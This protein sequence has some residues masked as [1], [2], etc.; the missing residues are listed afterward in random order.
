MLLQQGEYVSSGADVVHRHTPDAEI[1]FVTNPAAEAVNRSFNFPVKDRTP[2]LWDAYRGE[3]RKTH[4]WRTNNDSTAVTLNLEPDESVFVIFPK[5]KNNYHRLPSGE[6]LAEQCSDIDG[7]WDVRFEPK[8]A[9][10]FDR[11]L[12]VLTD[13]SASTDTAVKYFAGTATYQKT[14]RIDAGEVGKDK[15]ILLDLGA[16]H[17]I[18]EL[19]VN[20]KDAGV[21]WH[22]PY[23][24]DVTPYLK[25][26]DNT[27]SVA[28]SVNWANRLIG[29]EQYPADFE[30]GQDRGDL[31]RAMKAFPDWFINH[32]ARPQ[33]GRKT[34]NIWY[35]YRQD[36]PLQPA[37][38]IGQV[39]L[40]KQTVV[41]R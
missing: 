11:V 5:D 13:F 21:L 27:L 6:T 4:Q 17:D 25:A 41:I 15:R 38:L 18:A 23:K 34:F 29:D 33:A 31:G 26:G 37:G 2:E 20:G 40:V 19:Q 16:L 10:A 7:A 22:P 32:Q 28:V 35:Y 14:I 39:K 24:T 1:F 9:P 12:P 8:L 36:S 3:I 30:W